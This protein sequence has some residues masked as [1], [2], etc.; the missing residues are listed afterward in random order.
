MC[1]EGSLGFQHIPEQV[2][3]FFLYPPKKGRSV[4]KGAPALPS[5]AEC[6][7]RDV[8][9]CADVAGASVIPLPCAAGHWHRTHAHSS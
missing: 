6:L 5:S 1:L 3:Y 9:H 4:D 2:Q 8:Q 7:G